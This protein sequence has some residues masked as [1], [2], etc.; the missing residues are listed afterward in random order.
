[1]KKLCLFIALLFF[2]CKINAQCICEMTFTETTDCC[3]QM[4]YTLEDAGGVIPCLAMGF[5]RITINTN[6]IPAQSSEVASVSM[7]NA[8]LTYTV[9]AANNIV[10]VNSSVPLV[11]AP[12]LGVPVLLGTICLANGPQP[13]ADA[14]FR[15]DFSNSGIAAAIPCDYSFTKNLACGIPSEWTVLCG[16]D[17]TSVVAITRIHAFNDGVYVAGVK[18]YITGGPEYAVFSKYDINNGSLVWQKIMRDPTYFTDFAYIPEEDAFICVGRTTPFQ[19]PTMF[20]D[21]RS[22]LVK[23]DDQGNILASKFYNQVGREGFSQI[24]RHSNPPNPQFPYYVL[25]T[26]N[27]DPLP[28]FPPP[29]SYW[30]VPVVFNINAALTVNWVRRYDTQFPGVEY[31]GTRG[32]FEKGQDLVLTGN[33][34][35]DNDG[36]LIPINSS[37]GTP[38]LARE[39]HTAD[40]DLYEGLELPNG[41]V[42]V[43]G[44]DFG[45]D[46]AV[47]IILNNSYTPQYGLRYPDIKEFRE[48]GLDAN[49]R[50]YAVGPLKDGSDYYII[51]RVINTGTAL[52][53]DISAYLNDGGA[54]VP[55]GHIDVTPALDAIFYADARKLSPLT[56][57]P[58]NKLVAT[59][60]LNLSNNPCLTPYPQSP[61]SFTP[62]IFTWEILALDPSEPPFTTMMVADNLP[63]NCD[64]ACG[65]CGVTALFSFTVECFTIDFIN[66]SFGTAPLTYEWD[67]DCDGMVDATSQNPSWTLPDILPHSVCLT[68]TDAE[69]CTETYQA[70][71]QAQDQ[72]PPVVNCTDL[73]LPTDPGECFATMD[74]TYLT[75]T[76]NCF[77]N[78]DLIVKCEVNG[79]PLPPTLP[80]GAYVVICTVEDPMGNV[81]TCFFEVR[82]EDLEPPVAICPENI[83]MSNGFCMDDLA[84]TL[85]QAGVSDN[86]PDAI[87]TCDMTG[88]IMV[89]CGQTITITCMAEDMAGNTDICSY[90]VTVNCLFAADAELEINCTED[91][92]VFE[93]SIS[94][95]NQSGSLSSACTIVASTLQPGVTILSQSPIPT[96]VGNVGTISGTFTVTGPPIPVSIV[97]QATLNCDCFQAPYT[98]GASAAL[99]CCEEIS[100]G[101]QQICDG[102]VAQ[103]SLIG[104]SDLDNITQVNW[105]VAPAPCPPGSWGDPFLIVTDPT[106]FCN[107]LELYTQ[108]FTG[109]ICVYAEVV[110]SNDAGPCTL[111]VTNVVTIHI[112]EPVSCSISGGQDYCYTGAPIVT[113]PLTLNL[114]G[115][116]P[117]CNYSVQ[118][119]DANGLVSGATGLTFQPPA[120]SFPGAATD[121]YYD[122]VFTAEITDECGTRSCSATFRL[123]NDNAPVG[124]LVMDPVEAMPFCPGE[125]ATLRYTPECAGETPM[126]EWWISS[127]GINYSLLSDA[128]NMNPLY[129]TNKLYADTWYRVEKHVGGGCPADVVDLM[130]EVKTPLNITSFTAQFSPVCSTD[131]VVM[132]VNFTPCAAGGMCNCDY[133]VEW[134]KDATLL[135]LGTYNSSPASY[136]HTDLPNKM[137]G[138]YYAIIKDN[139][140]QGQVKK[141]IVVEVEKPWDVLILGPCFLC[142]PGSK[143]L[144]VAFLNNQPSGCNYQWTTTNGNILGLTNGTTV[145][146]NSEGTYHVAITCGTCTRQASFTLTQCII[147]CC[148]DY[149]AFEESVA[150]GFSVQRDECEVQLQSV[151]LDSCKQLIIEW[152]DGAQSG[153]VAGSSVLTHIYSGSGDYTICATV[154]EFDSNEALC[155]SKDTCWTVCIVC[156]TCETIVWEK[157]FPASGWDIFS[158]LTIGPN[159]E[160]YVIGN[161]G[162]TSMDI[163]GITLS[164]V[165]AKGDV[166]LAKMNPNGTVSGG[167]A[168]R[169]GGDGGI[170]DRGET[171]KIASNGDI[172]IGGRVTGS[173]IDFAIN[174]IDVNASVSSG[175]ISVTQEHNYIARYNSNF[176]LLWFDTIRGDKIMDIAFLKTDT[177]VA[178]GSRFI[179][180]APSLRQNFIAK[181]EPA[182]LNNWVRVWTNTH[183]FGGDGYNDNTWTVETDPVGGIYVCGQFN[184]EVTLGNDQLG[185]SGNVTSGYIAN[186]DDAGNY[187]WAFD[188]P[189]LPQS[190]QGGGVAFA[191]DI[192]YPYLFVI[193]NGSNTLDPTG[194]TVPTFADVT[195][196]I[197]VAKY[198]VDSNPTLSSSSLEWAFSIPR[199]GNDFNDIK[200]DHNGN[201]L[202]TG[203]LINANIDLDPNPAANPSALFTATGNDQDFFIAKY[204]DLYNGNTLP[205]FVCGIQV[206]SQKPDVSYGME[207]YDGHIFIAGA[208]NHDPFPNFIEANP[209]IG[210][211]DCPCTVEPSTCCEDVSIVEHV[212]PTD[213]TICC[214]TFDM[215]NDAGFDL[216][217]VEVELLETND[218]AINAGSATLTGGLV[219]SSSSASQLSIEHGSGKLPKGTSAGFLS[220]CL[221]K[222]TAQAVIPQTLV[223]RWYEPLPGGNIH[224]ACTDTI[225]IN[226]NIVVATTTPLLASFRLYPNPTTGNVALEFE[227]PLQQDHQ[228]RLLDLMGRQITSSKLSGG[229]ARFL[230]EFNSLPAGMYL[231]EVA[232]PNGRKEYRKLVVSY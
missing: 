63:F 109:D 190:N 209:Y 231:L 211:F 185:S 144:E 178:V 67:F 128:G 47:L 49:G 203:Q 150:A 84:V 71:V 111:L 35:P 16:D 218:W 173:N 212:V 175:L 50:I 24:L 147:S 154:S 195:G 51:N 214:Y 155:F 224:L 26:R 5:N 112:C 158:D 3:Y 91:P 77:S 169:F 45:T 92:D 102:G 103:L 201:L 39:F 132:T 42:L 227:Q 1:M 116:D 93:F 162:S 206:S 117:D 54:V 166:M 83:V 9:N 72:I 179:D 143:Q 232:D 125:D 76:D 30:D 194:S 14:F 40:F 205:T 223:F 180:F 66:Q 11:S 153:P 88:L 61:V 230:L 182:G 184:G 17:S 142:G 183:T 207:L 149:V 216:S 191:I 82:V 58:F 87:V 57:R 192:D 110:Q 23:F 8:T 15:V 133:T 140:C 131:E 193:G 168:Y 134:Y 210:K 136:T 171:I 130:I 79:S 135:H 161:V 80:K 59:L 124:T 138:N 95:N 22:V 228:A 129:N 104:C 25:G 44:T 19:T 113:G 160:I 213:S 181:Y 196:G 37:T 36:L 186:L 188:I 114:T 156:D 152:G 96:W 89:P 55:M 65:T 98:L 120:L 204:T 33:D 146:V 75:Y 52:Q 12:T 43:G 123:Y 122:H 141:S 199:V 167:H 163:D 13:P 85:P 115:S 69:G 208:L 2:T 62:Q 217:K 222:L 189:R 46:E 70:T 6:W 127:N 187:K 81:G 10:T 118:W 31:E 18:E 202:I 41:Q 99:P 64:A 48:V 106:A 74:G 198:R 229:Q 164:S 165:D 176:E 7:A 137:A 148:Q 126:W 101:D 177:M 151:A 60:D 34:I 78:A 197:Y 157:E 174:G 200:L 225:E 221:E 159:G 170:G 219:F 100:L 56:S 119:Y 32:F 29:P 86:C 105:Y 28:A 4:Y 215:E 21:N 145:M 108:Y 73:L 53:H 38:G 172:V 20:L 139:C 97:F 121:C 226:C 107:D 27:P 90:T 220:L 68:V 94:L